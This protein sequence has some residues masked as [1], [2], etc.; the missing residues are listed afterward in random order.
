MMG[1]IYNHK[2]DS[3]V[4]LSIL[5]SICFFL[6][7]LIYVYY[8]NAFWEYIGFN[9]EFDT[10]KFVISIGVLFAFVVC[11]PSRMEVRSFFLNLAL[12]IH[13]L[14]SLVLY[15]L[16]GMPTSSAMVVWLALM[17]V[18]VVSAIP[19]PRLKLPT[20]DQKRLMQVFSLATGGLIVALFAFGGGRNFNLDIRLVYELRDEASKAVPGIFSYLIPIF[21]KIII[22]FGVVVS[23][24]YRKFIVS[25][26]L[27][28]Y[29][30]ILFGIS[31]HKSIVVYPISSF[32]VYFSIEKSKKYSYILYIF[33]FALLVSI[34]DSILY[35]NFNSESIWGWYTSI[36][37][38][39]AIMVPSILDYY[40]IDFF[41]QNPYFFWASSR[42]TFGMI[43][44]PYDLTSPFLI[45]EAYFGSSQAGANTGYV[46]SGFAQAGMAG[47]AI[48]AIGVGMIVAILQSYGRYLGLPF[49]VAI[50]MTQIVTMISSTD[51]VTL[52][53]THG[54]LF[55]LVLLA[56]ARPL[57]LGR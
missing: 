56:M 53:L 26:V 33:I 8:I 14:P 11:T 7:C 30:I 12:T 28:L 55:S 4:K 15:S 50:M 34:F 19:V 5:Y 42:L 20:L 36:M 10:T 49:V 18:Y 51:F 46:G 47:V 1:R 43:N 13:L 27:I 9:Y 45:G 25:I 41:S 38:R 40:H 16:A 22:P 35:R 24:Y 21:S 37:V 3:K 31:S 52:F 17:I 39:R 57:H 48:Y 23:L 32:I 6:L 44:P 29:S 2:K 54:M